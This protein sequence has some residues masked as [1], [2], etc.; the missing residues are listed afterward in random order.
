MALQSQSTFFCGHPVVLT[1]PV[2][3]ELSL[4]LRIWLFPIC[5]WLKI[6]IAAFLLVQPHTYLANLKEA[7]SLRKMIYYYFFFVEINAGISGS[8]RIIFITFFYQNGK[9]HSRIIIFIKMSSHNSPLQRANATAWGW[10]SL[11]VSS[12]PVSSILEFSD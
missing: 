12:V 8:Q 2:F 1:F 11:A 3:L 9:Y 7:E 6:A 10:L 5:D 4:Q